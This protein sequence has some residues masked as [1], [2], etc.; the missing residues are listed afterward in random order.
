MGCGSSVQNTSEPSFHPKGTDGSSSNL[1]SQ[2]LPS[3]KLNGPASVYGTVPTPCLWLACTSPSTVKVSWSH[4][5]PSELSNT[6]FV[7]EMET[8]AGKGYLE[9]F[10][11]PFRANGLQESAVPKKSHGTECGSFAKRYGNHSAMRSRTSE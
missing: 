7:L 2:V 8:G 4:E 5:T 6:V 1:G 9:V 10:R 11:Y 3:E